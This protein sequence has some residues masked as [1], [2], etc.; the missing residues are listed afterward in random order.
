MPGLPS[1]TYLLS[2]HVWRQDHNGFSRQDPGSSTTSS[3]RAVAGALR[4]PSVRLPRAV[5]CGASL[6]AVQGGRSIDTAM[7]FTPLDG[8]VMATRSGRVDPGL[9]LWLQEH[10]AL[11][12]REVAAALEHHSGLLALA[13]SADMREILA[14]GD[15]AARLAVA[16]Y[17]HRLRAGIAAMTAAL[18]STRSC[19]PAGWGRTRPRCGPTRP[20]GSAGSGLPSTERPTRG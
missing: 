3:T 13:G 20:P 1:L 15:D 12:E 4:G 6:A 18:G 14:R 16:V 19:S 17:Q 11:P 10:E 2:S 9:V 7:G 5:A 8:L